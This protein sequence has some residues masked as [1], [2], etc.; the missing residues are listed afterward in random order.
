MSVRAFSCVL[1]T[2]KPAVGKGKDTAGIQCVECCCKSLYIGGK[3]SVVHQLNLPSAVATDAPNIRE[4]KRRQMGRSGPV[5]QLR[6]IPVLNHLLVLWDGSVTALNMFSLEP[7]SPL[8]KIPNVSCMEV[9]SSVSSTQ[10]VYVE[11]VTASV[12]R[13]WISVHRVY[14]DKWECVKQMPLGREPLA[15]AVREPCVCVATAD[16]YMLCDYESGNTLDLFQHNLA[17]QN[18]LVKQAGEREFL[19]NGPGSLGMFVM[20]DGI[21]QRPPVP[22][23]AGILDAAVCHPYTLVLQDQAQTVHV[24][25]TLDQ[26][27]KQVIPIPKAAT[28]TPTTEGVLVIAEREIYCL[29]PCA[30]E[31]QIEALMAEE[32]MDQALVLLDGVRELLPQHSYQDLRK[33]ISCMLGLMHFYQESFKEAKGLLIDGDLDPR[34]IIRLYPEVSDVCGDFDSQLPSVST[35]RDLR[36]MSTEDQASLHRFLHFLGDFLQAVRGTTQ[37]LSCRSDVDSALLKVYLQLGESE[38]LGQMVT[39]PNDCHLDLSASDLRQHK[40]FFAL[41]LLYQSHGQHFSA[42]QTWVRMAE[43]QYDD[44]S[45]TAADAYEHILSTLRQLDDRDTFWSFADWAVQRDQEAGVQIFMQDTERPIPSCHA[46]EVIPFLQKYPVSSLMYLE[47]LVGVL[48]SKE[49]SHH[50]LLAL[51]YIA[52][53]LQRSPGEADA[54]AGEDIRRK[55]QQLLW[56]S[57]HCDTVAVHDKIASTNLHTEKAILLGKT[58]EHKKALQIL[59]HEEKDKQAAVDYCWRTSAGRERD[60]RQRLFLSLLQIYLDST[61]AEGA[62]ADLLN[63]HARA[64]DAAAVLQA[65]P[66]AWSVQMVGSFLQEALRSAFHQRRM[67]QVE[68]TLTTAEQRRVTS[69]RTEAA[70]RMIKLERG[71]RCQVCQRLLARPEF[72]FMPTGEL[73]HL[74]CTTGGKGAPGTVI[75]TS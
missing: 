53:I 27:L 68:A 70:N 56:L 50:T 24:Y 43:G 38:R 62:A 11:L 57:A 16:R 21:S 52:R 2:E 63:R 30:L 69:T 7:V 9:G 31:D 41:G 44:S 51:A 12:K 22:W 33:N 42:I 75:T 3:D 74:H 28:L 39:S 64:F 5:S 49:E 73:V 20:S 35:S 60:F 26:Q 61:A 36:L 17:R 10:Q 55:L 23:P 47:Y 25:S 1:L 29:R 13:R 37:G 32:R 72:V 15:L 18:L 45:Q 54:S 8:K 14:V 67:R 66:A 48:K 65:L 19:L 34:E 71:T 40:R 4:V 6:A 46:D 59:V 58:G